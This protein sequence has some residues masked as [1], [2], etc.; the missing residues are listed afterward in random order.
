[1]NFLKRIKLKLYKVLIN[2]QLKVKPIASP[3]E[4]KRK[5]NIFLYFDYEREF[6]GHEINITDDHIA[7]ILNFL[8]EYTIKTT[9]FTVGEI[10]KEYPESIKLIS[11]NGH[12]LGSHTYNHIPSTKLDKEQLSDDF[13]TFKKISKN[14]PDYRF[15]P[16]TGE[17][18]SENN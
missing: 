15:S 16:A 10:F 11:K 3:D 1:M 8:D 14:Y 4:I 2:W 6:G 12:E 5:K 13:S 9:W 7:E 17:V 18:G